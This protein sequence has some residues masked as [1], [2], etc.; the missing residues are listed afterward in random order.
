MA[1]QNS[2]VDVVRNIPEL[3]LAVALFERAGLLRIFDCPGPF[4]VQLPIN[5]AIENI[6]PVTLEFLL[7]PGNVAD[8]QN[9]LLY[10]VLPGSFSTLDFAPGVVETLLPGAGVTIS[11]APVTF[12][13]A[14]VIAPNIPAG[15]GYIHAIDSVLRFQQGK[16]IRE[17]SNVVSFIFSQRVQ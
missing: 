11:I 14:N 12:N 7:Q 17:I 1:A 15:N 16:A 4:T 9:L 6:D 10:H 13:S 8:L 2:I 5:N 3:S